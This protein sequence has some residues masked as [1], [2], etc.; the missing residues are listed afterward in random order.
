MH[1]TRRFSGTTFEEKCQDFSRLLYRCVRIHCGKQITEAI[2]LVV[3]RRWV[4][5]C[6]SEAP[7]LTFESPVLSPIMTGTEVDTTPSTQD[8]FLTL[9][10]AE[11]SFRSEELED[12]EI[13]ANLLGW[14]PSDD[15]VL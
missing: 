9:S 3:I 15:D 2:A 12:A 11:L 6:L 13:A 14:A 7:I 8:S 10:S 5:A 4:A 1:L